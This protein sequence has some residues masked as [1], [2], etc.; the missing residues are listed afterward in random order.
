MKY[1]ILTIALLALA[2]VSCTDRLDVSPI[3]A[4]EASNFYRT[5]IEI[6]EAVNAVYATLQFTGLYNLNL[7]VLG[8]IPSDNTFDEVPAN[9][10]GNYGQLDEFTTITSNAIITATWKDAYVGIQRANTVLNRIED[11]DFN[12]EAVKDARKGEMRFIRALIYFNL[13]QIYG[14]VPLVTEETSDPSDYFG[15]ART[16]AAQ[17]YDQ[18]VTDL[19]QAAAELP[20]TPDRPGRVI[21]TAAQALLAKVQLTLGDYAAAK[22]ALQSVLSSG[23]H[24]LMDQ[25]ADVFD[26][27]NELNQEIIFAV[28]FASGVNGNTE[29]SDAFQQFSP[30][31]TVNG[32]KGH[33]LPTRDFYA[34]FSDDDLRKEAYVGATAEGV[35]F[36]KK[37]KQS[38]TAPN[39]GGS[40]WVVLRYADVLLMLA[41]VEN[42]LG[43]LAQADG[44]LNQIRNRAG[45]P[46]FTATDQG[47]LRDAI[48]LERRFEL[49][50][51]GHRWFDLK[52]T[53]Q[54]ISTMNAWFT[55]QGI[56]IAIDQNDLLMPIPQSQIDTDPALV[57]NPG[58]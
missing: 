18:I 27:A 43:N 36:T 24:R 7:P 54:A 55:A 3:T 32:A 56:N 34:M 30:S 37:Y 17:V 9:D 58:Y 53:G 48:E 52:R 16:P 44:Y 41:E 6:E 25:P 46:D 12:S 4:K 26:P 22:T 40:D 19:T 50:G 23:Q 29:G 14:D 57:Q 47:D 13:A 39:D 1:T 10:N 33:N 38:S 31:G 35:P 45:L 15:Q 42:E 28:Q 2:L 21:K 11:V 5:E 8:E 49:I 20:A 51:E